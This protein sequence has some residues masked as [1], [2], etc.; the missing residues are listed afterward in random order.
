MTQKMEMWKVLILIILSFC[1]GG[2]LFCDE[3]GKEKIILSV[4]MCIVG[5]VVLCVI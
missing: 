1:F 4:I 2:Y 3:D 5:F